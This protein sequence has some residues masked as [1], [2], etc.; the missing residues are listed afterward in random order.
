[1]QTQGVFRLEI[2]TPERMFLQEDVEALN[3]TTV[4]GKLEILRHHAPIT[5]PLA[6]GSIEV[7]RNGTWKAAFQS[8]GFLEVNN[9]GVFVFAQA[10]E[11]PENI[12]A[13]RAAEAEARV[14]ERMRQQRS[15]MEYQWSKTAL[16]RAAARLRM[17]AKNVNS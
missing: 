7:K 8:E 2:M 11:W 9:E 13:A 4:D 15:M 12:D 14:K 5:A 3:V 16:A 6:V 17:T 1:M 10:C